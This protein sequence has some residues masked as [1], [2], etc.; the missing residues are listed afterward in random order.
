MV[1]RPPENN[2]SAKAQALASSSQLAPEQQVGDRETSQE[3]DEFSMSQPPSAVALKLKKLKS[4]SF[5]AAQARERLPHPLF[6]SLF[7]TEVSELKK[8]KEEKRL[9]DRILLGVGT[10]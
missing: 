10:E 1:N 9:L 8:K 2:S 6:W 7:L 3:F 4:A 5:K